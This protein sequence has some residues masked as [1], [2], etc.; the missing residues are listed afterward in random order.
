MPVVL[1]KAQLEKA[2]GQFTQDETK[3]K[4]VDMT[5]VGTHEETMLSL[6]PRKQ[7]LVNI[8][9]EDGGRIAAPAVNSC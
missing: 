6:I 3:R 5:S 7:L 4:R 2:L 9:E 1:R 8:E